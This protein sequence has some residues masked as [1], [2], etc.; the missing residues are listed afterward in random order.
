MSK[1]LYGA[2]VQGIQDFIFQTNKLK[3]I[4]GASELVESICTTVFWE[5]A[6]ISKDDS[7]I[8]LNA[9]GNIKYLFE[10]EEKCKAFVRIFPKIVM[11]RAPG[12][13]I[14]QAVVKLETGELNKSLK[15][16]EVKLRAQR[17]KQSKPFEMG[18]MG[19]DRSRRT[20]GVAYGH[21]EDDKLIC[22]A[23]FK[24]IAIADPKTDS[25]N[26]LFQKVSGLENVNKKSLALN[27]EEITKSGKNSWIAVIHADGNALGSIIQNLGNGLQNRTDDEVKVAFK[28]FSQKI[29]AA[30]KAAAQKAFASIQTEHTNKEQE[31]N[32]YRYPLRPIIL[33][34]DDLTLIIR[35]DLALDF[36]STFLRAFEEETEK[37]FD[38][39]HKQFGINGYE[40][41][42]TACAGIA[43]VKESYPLHYAIGLA[44]K[45]CKDAKKFV[46]DKIKFPDYDQIPKSSLAFF[47]V[48][49]SFIEDKLDDLKKR[50]LKA[51]SMSFDY[52]PYLIE[53]ANNGFSN[54]SELTQKLDILEKEALENDKSKAVSKLRQWISELYK[55]KTTADFMLD[56]MSVVNDKFYDEL[57]MNEERKKTTSII[58]DVIQ[59]HNLKY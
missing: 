7:N 1:Y 11:E 33:G 27:I 21:D 56:R 47:K 26:K 20:G 9:A 54:V 25:P 31:Q 59:L 10:T 46:K 14:S 35:A 48:Q 2:S 23:T 34:G 3:E 52:G 28:T 40:K 36:T 19:V 38:F 24:K 44:D 57:K 55:D 42:I 39:L 5:V 8:I 49:D 32:N 16:L 22:E 37:Q 15:N 29:E 13:T 43:F 41:G 53:P 6:N 45:L 30:T 50:T 12:I 4:V 58:Y 17:N 51:G 18:F